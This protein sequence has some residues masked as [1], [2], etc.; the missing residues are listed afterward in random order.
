MIDVDIKLGG[1]IC[2][3]PNTAMSE[4]PNDFSQN[5]NIHFNSFIQKGIF[6]AKVILP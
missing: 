4:H 3:F 5:N 1:E 2:E 6:Y